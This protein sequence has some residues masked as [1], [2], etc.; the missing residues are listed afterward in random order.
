[1]ARGALF[2]AGTAFLALMSAPPLFAQD[3]VVE[4]TVVTGAAATPL[5][6]AQV[7]VQGTTN[8]AVT[9]AAGRFR[10]AN[11]TGSEVTL[12]VRRIGFRMES[13]RARVGDRDVR[14]ALVERA[15]DLDAVVVT[16]VAGATQKKRLGNAVAT[17]DAAS[18]T[19][20]Q[21]INNLQELLNGRA[22]GVFVLPTSGAVGTGS[23]I[24]VRGA[25]S[26]SLSNEP[27][28]YVDGVR[29][30]N[31]T[32]V[33][34]ET[35]AFGSKPISRLNDINPEDIESIEIIKGPAAAT[36]YGTEASN[37]VIQIITK[38][39]AAGA[40]RW[41]FSM[42]QGANFFQDPEGR[43]WLNYQRHPT[44]NE[45]ITLDI[46]E[47]ENARGTPIFRTGHLQEYDLNVSGGSEAFRYY[48][49]GGLE[50]SE[51]AEPNNDLK[52]YNARVNFSLTPSD[53]L[54]LNAN[55]GY[56]DGLTNLSPEAGFGGRMFTTVLANP[57][58]LITAPESRG[59]HSGR[60]ERYDILQRF[61]Q[62]VD[63]FTLGAQITHTPFTWFQH[64]LNVGRDRTVEENVIYFPRID[65]LVSD[66]SFGTSALGSKEVNDRTITYT[67]VDYS[68]TGS[69]DITPELRS[70]TSVGG[71]YYRNRTD[72]VFATGEV[73]PT[74]GLSA[75]SATTVDRFN[76]EDFVEDATVGVYVQEQIGW[77]DRLFLTA[78]VRSDDNSAFGVNFDR[79]TYP[80]FSASWVISEEPFFRIPA[81]NSLRFRAAYGESGKQPQT[82]SSIR[83]FLPVTG[84][85]NLAAA[86]PQFIGNPDLGPER[87]KEIEVG[88]DAGLWDD[89]VGVEL[90]YYHKRTEDAILQREFAPSVGFPGLQFFNAGEVRNSGL[91]LLLRGRPIDRDAISWDI[92]FSVATN[93]SEVL[94]LGDP[95]VQFVTAGTALRHQVG[96]PIGAWFEQ[97]VVSAELNA[98]GQAINVMCD[99]GQGGSM[100]CRGADGVFGNADDAPDV[101]LGRTTPDV[102][103]AVS[104]TL[105]FL[106]NFRLSALVDFKRGY[107]KIDGNTRVRCAFFGGRC[108]ENFFPEEFDPKRI[109]AIQSSNN[110]IDYLIDDSGYAKLR[111]V[112]LSFVVPENW[113]RRAG[114]SRATLTVAGRNLHTWTSFGGLEPEANFLSGSRG[115]QFSA[116]EQT[117]L[118]QLTQWL[119][120]INLTF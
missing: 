19:E 120:S 3:G 21:P 34:P 81:V 76:A 52:R 74:P 91:E 44:T 95:G 94:S 47:A 58:R 83:T 36:L 88:F 115:G 29:V 54:V 32:G 39:G 119:A 103:G 111:E 90:T 62:D 38:R 30:N 65:S 55:M 89:R 26:F 10:I 77:R 112:S 43:L 53:K 40:A 5:A 1:R 73:F 63:R 102:E 113:A 35:Q 25:S 68:A 78:A 75:V 60:P 86:T 100:P 92:T 72:S 41:N 7:V 109:A 12:E 79:V 61:W 4:G 49:G 107:R 97:R 116:W 48:V 96:S 51:G 8:G 22:A 71:Q 117:T 42:K 16:G 101:F 37:G 33:G 27:L 110:L 23:R 87:G 14:V 17:I 11:L 46:V 2:A 45:I 24:R 70:S 98:T 99:D 56:T 104:S 106:R 18:V 59:Y 105:T 118:P 13:V 20:S 67:T 69:F 84:P 50:Q 66:P 31:A 57:A 114:A 15:V 80:K 82:F 9:D 108:R 6:A 93:D 85:G 64:R 28:L